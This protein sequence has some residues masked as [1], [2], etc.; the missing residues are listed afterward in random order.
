MAPTACPVEPLAGL[1][2]STLGGEFTGV[3]ALDA[4][5][6]TL[7]PTPLVAITRK[8]Y[9]VPLSSPVTVAWVAV[10]AIPV[11][12]R[13]TSPPAITWIL[14]SEVASAPVSGPAVHRT[15]AD[16]SPASAVPMF[17]WLGGAGALIVPSANCNRSMLVSVST[18]SVPTVSVTVTA[19]SPV[20][21]LYSA[22][23]RRT[24]PCRCHWSRS[25]SPGDH[26][27][28]PG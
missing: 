7:S 26:D 11:T 16:P 20:V 9:D 22:A 13:T 4:A 19:P 6:G 15:S 17:G 2:N 1:A 5:D 14:Y 24:V 12:V 28:A 18:P 27:V 3:T 23:D 21:M 25:G 10:G 8:V